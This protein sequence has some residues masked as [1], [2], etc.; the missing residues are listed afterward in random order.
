MVSHAI[1]LLKV[2]LCHDLARH[3]YER[4]SFDSHELAGTIAGFSSL[5]IQP[6]L[7]LGIWHFE[8]GRPACHVN[9]DTLTILIVAK[10]TVAISQ[11]WVM[12]N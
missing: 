1:V 5:M 11:Q 10:K 2:L 6:G 8:L 3:Q 4:L 7:F 9:L 12:D